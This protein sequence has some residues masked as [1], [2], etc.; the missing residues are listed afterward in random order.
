MH[1]WHRDFQENNSIRYLYKF[2]V[3]NEDVQ[4]RVQAGRV[5]E[6]ARGGIEEGT[7]AVAA[8]EGQADEAGRQDG[9]GG[10]LDL[11][12]KRSHGNCFSKHIPLVVKNKRK[13][14]M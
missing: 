14:E 8:G 11:I 9:R 12:E 5:P 1:H 13:R 10:A 4:Q 6:E 7:V 3:I 2:S